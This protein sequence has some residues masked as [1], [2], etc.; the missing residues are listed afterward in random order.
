VQL[1]RCKNPIQ[2]ARA[3]FC[4]I[5]YQLSHLSRRAAVIIE[6]DASFTH[7]SHLFLFVPPVTLLCFHVDTRLIRINGIT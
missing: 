6:R 4:L 2:S 1:M 5:R 3:F 7:P